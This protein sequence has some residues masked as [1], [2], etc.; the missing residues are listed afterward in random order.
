MGGIIFAPWE[1]FTGV[2]AMGGGENI[3]NLLGRTDAGKRQLSKELVAA[4]C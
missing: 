1:I 3:S 2:L 4:V